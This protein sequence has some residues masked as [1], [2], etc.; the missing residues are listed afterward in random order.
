[1]KLVKK[2]DIHVHSAKRQILPVGTVARLALP[3]ELCEMYAKL[4]IERGVLLPGAAPDC[5]GPG[6]GGTNEDIY[7]VC[8]EYPDN[9][10]W[11]CNIDPR[12][13]TNS[14]K[15]DFVPFLEH[16]KSLGAKGIGEMTSN[17]NFDDPKVLALMR[18]CEKVGMPMTFHIGNL[19]GDYG[20]V[21]EIG[22]PRLEKCLQMFPK[23]IFLGH[24]QKFWAEISGDLTEELRGGYPTGPVAPGGRVVELMRKYPNLHADLSAGSGFNAISRDPEFGY[25]F[26]EE[27]QDKL[28][29]GTDICDPR[30][31]N[32]A[33]VLLSKY[34]D[35][36]VEA[37]K[38]SY[39]AYYKISRGN[40][41]KLLGL[42]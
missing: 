37:G 22:L 18:D 1:M 38:I 10:S 7:E 19:G 42:V 34:L 15:T 21:D 36:A 14:D 13:G 28:F 39:D 33:R 6:G 20:L 16:Y 26:F 11:F 12:W 24:S 32:D 4:N 17:L 3:H 30:N 9:F 27:F 5:S 25:K 2:I 29:F 23:L 8:C 31:I 40:A 41:E 35:D